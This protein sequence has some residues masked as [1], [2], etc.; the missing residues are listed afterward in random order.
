MGHRFRTRLFSSYLILA[1]YFSLFLCL[2]IGVTK[3]E[4]IALS[5]FELHPYAGHSLENQGAVTEIVTAAFSASGE[6]INVEFY[7]TKR[8][9][10]QV[11]KGQLIGVY[12][13]LFDSTMNRDL[14]LSSPIPG[15]KPGL[16]R[17][18]KAGSSLSFPINNKVIGIK[19]G[20]LTPALRKTYKTATFIEINT[21]EQ[22]LGMLYLERIDYL[23]VDKYIAADLMV[24]RL[25][26]LIGQMEFST[27]S[28]K[29]ANLHVGFSKNNPMGKKAHALFQVGLKK[30]MLDGS[31]DKIL[32]RHGLQSPDENRKVLRIATVENPEMLTMQRLSSIYQ[33]Q[34]P[35]IKLEWLVIDETILRRRLLSDLA[36]SDGQYD[37]MTI[38]AYE[39]PI[40]AER[41]WLRPILG[42]SQAYDEK[43]LIMN[44]SESLTFKQQLFAL[45]FYGESAMTYYRKDLFSKAQLIMPP[46]PSWAQITELAAKLHDPNNGVYGICLRGKVGWG[47]NVAIL[48]SMVNAYGGQWFDMQWQAT[49]DSPQWRRAASRYIELVTKYGPPDIDQ[50]GYMESLALFS[51]GHCGMWVDATVAA[52]TLF[53][54]KKSNVAG[55]VSYAPAPIGADDRGSAWLWIWSL[56][57]PASTHHA[58]EAQDFIAWATSRKYIE[59]VAKEE[60]WGAVPPGTRYSTY[61]NKHYQL[62]APYSE[63]VLKEIIKS[64]PNHPTFEPSPYRGLQ[65]AAIPEFPALGVYV[66]DKVN[67]VIKGEITLEQ[68]LKDSQD[69]AEKTMRDAGYY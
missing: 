22:L 4:N 1:K 11:I 68:A 61:Y 55:A 12:P 30:I 57:I 47:E 44:I 58:E 18:K 46:S 54:P 62:A 19:V 38:G 56:A 33:Q 29:P 21:N 42:L 50:N 37:I 8:A 69:F 16:L 10:S 27:T 51:N 63:Y 49:I 24:D 17:K 39:T 15:M 28:I 5:T 23:L 25:P 26:S 35:E 13:I 3:A 40:W 36:I 7:P 32:Y 53:N 60:G 45:P 48:S 31:L 59:L 65:F 14:I 64:T 20:S 41:G 9:I 2:V 34:H 43:D 66:G 67:Q 52:S 6:E